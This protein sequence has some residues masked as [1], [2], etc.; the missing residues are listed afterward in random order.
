MNLRKKST[1]K[2]ASV[3]KINAETIQQWEFLAKIFLVVIYVP[4]MLVIKDLIEANISS[5]GIPYLILDWIIPLILADLLHRYYLEEHKNRN[6]RWIVYSGFYCF[7][8]LMLTNALNYYTIMVGGFYGLLIVFTKRFG[9]SM[10]QHLLCSIIAVQIMIALNYFTDIITA[11][12]ALLLFTIAIMIVFF[13]KEFKM[14]MQEPR[15]PQFRVDA[16]VRMMVSELFSITI[17]F[18][19][20]YYL[21]KLFITKYQFESLHFLVISLI[22][23]LIFYVIFVFWPKIEVKIIKSRRSKQIK[24]VGTMQSDN[25]ENQDNKNGKNKDSDK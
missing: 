12:G 1:K 8:V 6:L 24:E 18:L 20:L 5:S 10:R 7:G 4:V 25:Q 23:S 16:I 14:I 13:E 15:I 19:I 3:V 9:Y 21:P 22:I 17:S 11:Y 2:A